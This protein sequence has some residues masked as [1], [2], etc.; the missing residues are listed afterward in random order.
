MI[1]FENFIIKFKKFSTN[2][3]E[4]TNNNLLFVINEMKNINYKKYLL[5]VIINLKINSIL[6]FLQTIQ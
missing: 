6:L 4:I 1:L 2:I 3:S 5:E